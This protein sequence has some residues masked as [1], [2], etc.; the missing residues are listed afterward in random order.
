MK[1]KEIRPRQVFDEY[2][3]LSVED[4]DTYFGDPT[5][6]VEVAC[7]ACAD[8]R[9]RSAFEK[10]GFGYVVCT[11]CGTLYANP[12]P[13]AALLEKYYAEGKAPRFWNDHFFRSTADARRE[14]IF[15]PRARRLRELVGE[16]PGVRRETLVDVGAG[17]GI[18]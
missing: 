12:R 13:P 2:L 6:F 17:F 3:A 14:K 1:E 15:V 5:V 8:S 4:I 9:C 16:V 11:R 18:F 7:P 10:H